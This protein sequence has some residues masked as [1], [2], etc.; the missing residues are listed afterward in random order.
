MHSPFAYTF[1]TEVLNDTRHFYAY[2]KIEQLRK[3][4]LNQHRTIMV[5]DYGAGSHK[6]NQQQRTIA[7]IA[8]HAAKQKK[9]GK[10]LLKMV[11]Y[12]Q[13]TSILELGTSLGI[14]TSYIASGNAQAKIITIEGSATIAQEATANFQHLQLQNI[15]QVVGTFE[16][17]LPA[18]LQKNAPFDFVFIDGNHTYAATKKYFQDIQ[19]KLSAKSILIFD[20]IHWSAGMQQAWQEIIKDSTTMLS[21]DVF[22][23]GIIFY[24]SSFKEKQ[25]FILKM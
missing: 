24:D 12:Y 2:E 18:V 20:D 23:F 21:I 7:S 4:L 11:N 17:A 8:K 6:N 16:E 14:G 25:H 9:H 3:K 10:L 5:Q 22:Q 1:N 19:P 13:P 15:E